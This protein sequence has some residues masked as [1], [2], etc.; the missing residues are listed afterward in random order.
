MTPDVGRRRFLAYAVAAPVLVVAGRLLD[1]FSAP[2]AHAGPTPPQ[3]GDQVDL[4]DLLTYA[5]MPTALMATLRVDSDGVAHFALPRTEVGQGL[6]TMVTQLI[7]EELDQPLDKIVVTLEKARPDL[8]LNQ[9]TGG[10][11]ST[12]S[13]YTPTRTIAALA[14]QRLR[15]AAAREWGVAPARVTTRSGVLMGPGGRTA[16]YG[17]MAERAASR[18][19]VAEHVTLKPPSDFA[20]IGRPLGRVDARAAVTG[21]KKFTLD[22]DVPDALPTMI[23]RAPTVNGTVRSVANLAA[24]RSM[25]GV[26]DVARLRTGV[27]VRA[28]TFGQCIDAVNALVVDWGPGTVD[29]QSDRSVREALDRAMEPMPPELP[30]SGGVDMTFRFAFRN[31]SALEPGCAIADVRADRAEIWTCA[32]A[33][34]VALAEIA[35]ELGLSPT[36]VTLNVIP[37]GGSFGR[38]LFTDAALDAALASQAMGKPVRLMV[39]RTDD[40]RH[41]RMHPMAVSHVRALWSG[42]DV[43]QMDQRH[44]CV[45]LDLSSGMGDVVAASGH[46]IPGLALL[47]LVKLSYV[48][49]QNV[50]YDVGAV[51]QDVSQAFDVGQFRTGSMRQVFSPD[52]RT[53]TEL[54]IDRIAEAQGLDPYRFRMK[55][56]RDDRIRACLREA[57]RVGDWG[58]TLPPGVAQ[59]VGVHGEYR[60]AAAV[61]VEIDCSEATTSRRIRNAIAGPRVTRVVVAV[62]VGVA[63]NP[64]GLEAQMQGAVMDGIAQT[65][66]AGLHF[67]RGIPLEGS[68]DDYFYTRQWNCPLDL[69]VVV[70]PPT[71]ESPGGAGELAVA[72]TMA[73]VACAYARATGVVPTQFPIAHGQLGFTPKKRS[74]LP[75]SPV[76]GLAHVF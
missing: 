53:A 69:T 60:S 11:N 70:M 23:R 30:H 20:V 29:G 37:G 27:A 22:L 52:S 64:R 61:L 24:V 7:A 28:R 55:Y 66:T 9:Q 1:P 65:L 32:K 39:H 43:V 6:S 16:S 41:G 40:V 42:R 59:G 13:I 34:S 21:Q 10:S 3:P 8:L 72:P 26:T 19:D 18:T 12:R 74:V 36:A 71:S 63:V 46:L 5:A 58:R 75:P 15:A 31:I 67:D 4:G 45:Q 68:W 54:V 14:R 50:P 56:L 57:A 33:P 62:D 35:V 51:S 2:R 73:A 44:S 47:P 76:D 17:S 48:L 38:A 25:P 49:S